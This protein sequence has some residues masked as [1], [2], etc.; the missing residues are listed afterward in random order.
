MSSQQKKSSFK[1]VKHYFWDVPLLVKLCAD[2]VI[3]GFHS[4]CAP[5]EALDILEACH[6]GPTGGHHGANLT[7]KKDFSDCEDSRARGFALHPQEKRISHKRTKNKAKNDKTE[8][9]MEKTKSNRSQSQSKSK[10][11]QV[12]KI[13]LEGLKLPNLKLYYKNKQNKAEMGNWLNSNFEVPHTTKTPCEA[14]TKEAQEI[15]DDWAWVAPGPE[16]QQLVAAGAP[17]A[18]EDAPAVDEGAQANPAP[19]QAPQ[20]PPPPPDAGSHISVCILWYDDF[21]LFMHDRNKPSCK[22]STLVREYVTEPSTLSKSRA[23]LRRESVYKSVEAEE[24]SNLKTS[25]KKSASRETTRIDLAE[26]KEID[27]VGGESTISKSE[28]VGVWKLQDGC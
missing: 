19:I 8:H 7:A 13:Q 9:G 17:E 10:V 24:K 6:N 5:L 11:N 26:R 14:L 20:T 27:N 23:E 16:R 15:G 3:G 25:G 1:D 18:A 22:F 21:D 12:K 4:L 28:S 2:Q